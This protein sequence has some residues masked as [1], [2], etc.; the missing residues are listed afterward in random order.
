MHRRNARFRVIRISFRHELGNKIID[1]I[2]CM[3]TKNLSIHIFSLDKPNQISKYSPWRVY[4][5]PKHFCHIVILIL[6][7]S[8]IT[9]RFHVSKRNCP[10]PIVTYIFMFITNFLKYYPLEIWPE[11]ANTECN[12]SFL[13]KIYT[14]GLYILKMYLSASKWKYLY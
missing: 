2:Y 13:Q 1:M 6:T 12:I 7:W 8:I 4:T 10:L 11:R 5:H 9:T 14:R 3:V